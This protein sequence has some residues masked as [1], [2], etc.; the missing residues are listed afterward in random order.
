MN[1]DKYRVKYKDTEYVINPLLTKEKGLSDETISKIISKHI[2][3]LRVYEK[4][5]K[6]EDD[7]T[8]QFFADM[9]REIEFELQDLWGFERDYSFHEWYLVP[10]CICPKIDNRERRGTKYQI[11]DLNCPIHGNCHD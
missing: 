3:K 4:M 5:K 8:L 1:Y 9:V 6:A 2:E 11:I 10:G 7:N